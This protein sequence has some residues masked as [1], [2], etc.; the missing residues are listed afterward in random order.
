LKIV[1]SHQNQLENCFITLEP[2]W[3]D[4]KQSLSRFKVEIRG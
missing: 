3:Q 4:R 1:L 2:T